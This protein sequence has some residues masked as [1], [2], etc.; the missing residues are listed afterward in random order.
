MNESIIIFRTGSYEFLISPK[1]GIIAFYF[2]GGEKIEMSLKEIADSTDPILLPQYLFAK[3]ILYKLKEWHKNTSVF[4]KC[5]VVNKYQEHGN[6]N[7]MRPGPFGNHFKVKPWGPYERGEAVLKFEQWFCS[8]DILA[9]N[10]RDLVKKTIKRG[11]KLECCCKPK[12]C[13]CDIV[14]DYVNNDYSLDG[15]CSKT[16]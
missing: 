1:E 9:Q 10:Y 8:D 5:T 14:A 7:M 16:V 2:S 11:M 13:H 12:R 15:L 4:D 6:I 3:D